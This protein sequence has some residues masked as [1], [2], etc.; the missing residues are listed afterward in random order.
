VEGGLLLDVCHVGRTDADDEQEKRGE[1][2]ERGG[3]C[4]L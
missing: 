3:G 4:L 2:G 1:R